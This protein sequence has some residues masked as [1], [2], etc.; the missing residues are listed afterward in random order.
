MRARKRFGQH[1]LAPAWADKLVEALEPG[2]QDR[3]LEIGPGPGALTLRLAPRVAHVTAVE[4]DRDLA[5]ALQPRLPA[6]V[7]LIVADFLAADLTSLLAP[8]P[9][10]VAGNLPYNISSPILFRL[11]EM[12]RGEPSANPSTPASPRR[13]GAR[14]VDATLMLQR[15]VAERL[16]AQPGTGDYGVLSIS[17]Q[18]HAGVKRLLTLPPGAFRPAPSVHSALVR[19]TFRPPAAAPQDEALFE[20]MVRSM[21]TQ[22][23][24]TLAN[25]LAPFAGSR[26]M[27]AA[28][29]LGNAG[30]DPR[31]RPE[32]LDLAELTR[33]A[34]RFAAPSTGAARS[35][36]EP[37]GR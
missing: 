26:G 6:N 9:L 7:E 3:F 32:T 16:E 21:F 18:L 35:G 20:A 36:H 29:A 28:A 11:I 15:E 37:P 12:A 14:L 13:G 4:V 24:K 33:L 31:R 2:D 30:I 34:D 23:R 22:R 17:V 8:G 5:A 19:L 1:F 27:D 10:R 25:A